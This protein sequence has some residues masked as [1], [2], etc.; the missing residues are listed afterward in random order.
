MRG[1][2]ASPY[3]S[4]SCRAAAAMSGTTMETWFKPVIMTFPSRP[5][6]LCSDDFRMAQLR[7][8]LSVQPQLALGDFVVLLP[9]SRRCGPHRAAGIGKLERDP[10]HLER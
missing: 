4:L 2:T 6:A 5:V 1:P 7:D 3:F 10:E 9:E 8:R